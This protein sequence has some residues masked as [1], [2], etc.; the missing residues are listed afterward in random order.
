MKSKHSIALEEIDYP[1]YYGIINGKPWGASFIIYDGL[2]RFKVLNR[3]EYDNLSRSERMAISRFLY[4]EAKRANSLN[5]SK[6]RKSIKGYFSEIFNSKKKKAR[7]KKIQESKGWDKFVKDL[8]KRQRQNLK[9]TKE[10]RIDENSP[11]RE[12]NKRYRE[13]WKNSTRWTR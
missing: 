13:D 4:A 6:K 3:P 1:Y 12:Y 9:D 11:Q 2:T 7:S 8:D 10:K 5:E